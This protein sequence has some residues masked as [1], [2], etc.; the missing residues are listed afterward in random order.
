M[1]ETLPSHDNIHTQNNTECGQTEGKRGGRRR[2]TTL[3]ELKGERSTVGE[4]K[5]S[6]KVLF[7]KSLMKSGNKVNKEMLKGD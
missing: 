5:W 1:Q 3:S 4:K 7:V 6:L 2:L